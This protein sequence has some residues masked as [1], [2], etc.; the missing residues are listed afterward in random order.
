MN[1]TVLTALAIAAAG[2]VLIASTLVVALLL[3]LGALGTIATIS[4]DLPAGQRVAVASAVAGARRLRLWS[5][6]PFGYEIAFIVA[7]GAISTDAALDVR[8]TLRPHGPTP[9]DGTDNTD[10]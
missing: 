8:D 10:G 1:A 9:H 5:V 7:A 2:G 4:P 3:R 6:R